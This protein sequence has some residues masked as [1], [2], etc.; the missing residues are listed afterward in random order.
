MLIYISHPYGNNPENIKKVEEIIHRLVKEHPENTYISPIHCFGFMYNS[1][2][3]EAGLEMCL[4]LLD[5]C[6]KMMVFGNW[7][8]SR[9][10]NAEILHASYNHTCFEIVGEN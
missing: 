7:Q 2:S 10:C 3:Y 4:N 8:D 5:R 1:V 9:G 6:E